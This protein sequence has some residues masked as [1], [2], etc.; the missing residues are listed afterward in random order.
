MVAEVEP[1]QADDQ[2]DRRRQEG[3][4]TAEGS[5]QSIA[6][7]PDED[8]GVD[9]KRAEH[10]AEPHPMQKLLGIQDAPPHEFLLHQGD[11]GHAPAKADA[12]DLEKQQRES[13]EGQ[14]RPCRVPPAL[15][16]SSIRALPHAA[17]PPDRAC[18]GRL[19]VSPF[20]GRLLVAGDADLLVPERTA[21]SFHGHLPTAVTREAG[22]GLDPL[23]QQVVHNVANVHQ[24]LF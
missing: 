17:H 2:E 11:G 21:V 24:H 16:R 20:L 4:S 1:G 18:D 14:R 8:R 6:A 7:V 23:R 12:A 10:L 19:A 13:G 15:R 5:G 22:K 3:R 9:G